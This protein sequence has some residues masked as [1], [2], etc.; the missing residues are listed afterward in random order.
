[1]PVTRWTVLAAAHIKARYRISYADAFA[2][3]A[4]QEHDGVLVTGD[5]EFRSVADDNL[6]RVESL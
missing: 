2:V 1:M 3:V 5:H 4:A 6:L